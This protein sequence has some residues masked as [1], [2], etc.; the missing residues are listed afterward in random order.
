MITN[1]R[2][3]QIIKVTSDGQF[4]TVVYFTERYVKV[5]TTM[6]DA[7]PIFETFSLRQI[8]TIGGDQILPNDVKTHSEVDVILIDSYRKLIEYAIKNECSTSQA[9]SEIMEADAYSDY[10][11]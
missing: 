2:I 5:M 6:D 9:I 8:T 3:G 11:Q 4:R 7:I 1:L 10:F